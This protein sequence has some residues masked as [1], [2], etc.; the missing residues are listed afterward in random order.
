[1]W[2]RMYEEK[3]ALHGPTYIAGKSWL[4]AHRAPASRSQRAFSG[5]QASTALAAVSKARERRP[6]G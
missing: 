6:P 2:R 4:S 3:D 5:A 1:M